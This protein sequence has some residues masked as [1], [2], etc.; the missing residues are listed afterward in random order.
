MYYGPVLC[1]KTRFL[2]VKNTFF[3]KDTYSYHQLSHLSVSASNSVGQSIYIYIYMCVCVYDLLR[4]QKVSK[5][6]FHW[7]LM[8]LNKLGF[9]Y[10]QEECQS[11]IDSVFICVFLIWQ[12]WYLWKNVIIQINMEFNSLF[13]FLVTN[14][15]IFIEKKYDTKSC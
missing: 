9:Q 2:Y 6:Q 4:I 14:F 3:S 8:N 11:K 15:Y 10:C 12:K 1:I 5:V 7:P 13:I